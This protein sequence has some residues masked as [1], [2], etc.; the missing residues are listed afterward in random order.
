MDGQDHA[1]SHEG[2]RGCPGERHLTFAFPDGAPSDLASRANAPF[3]AD[4]AA[5]EKPRAVAPARNYREIGTF[6]DTSVSHNK[7]TWS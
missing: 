5:P 6:R 7:N 4:L 1:G 3:I 2:L